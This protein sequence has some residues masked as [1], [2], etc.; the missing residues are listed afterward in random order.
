MIRDVPH[1]ADV[2][3][4]SSAVH[5]LRRV[6]TA[7]FHS[8]QM[9]GADEDEAEAEEGAGAG[10]GSL[11][12][13][14]FTFL[15]ALISI[16]GTKDP[17]SSS[18]KK[19]KQKQAKAGS[20]EGEEDGAPSWLDLQVLALSTAA[21]F[22]AHANS[23]AGQVAQGS[24]SLCWDVTSW[25]FRALLAGGGPSS[26]SAYESTPSSS[27]SSASPTTSPELIPLLTLNLSGALTTL[28]QEFCDDY[29][30]V[31]YAAVRI[32]RDAC[33][34]KRVQLAA[35]AAAATG[36]KGKKGL[37]PGSKRRRAEAAADGDEG[38]E[39]GDGSA[40]SALGGG[41][42][43]LGERLVSA[44]HSH[45]L[46]RN[47]AD[48]LLGI[49]LPLD[50]GEWADADHASFAVEQV[51]EEVD[52]H[53]AAHGLPAER[54]GGAATTDAAAA[55]KAGKK[56]AKFLSANSDSED[57]EQ[58]G[59]DDEEADEEEEEDGSGGAARRG[60]KGGRRGKSASAGPRYTLLSEQRRAY[61]E[62]WIALLRL[63]SLPADVVRRVLLALPTRVLPHLVSER[64]PLLLADF[65]TDAC[66]RGGAHALLALQSLFD[67]MQRHGLEYPR[68]YPR[69]YALLTPETAA[70][71]YRGKYLT[72]L[73]LFLSSPALPAY[74]T[75]AFAKRLA[76]VALTAPFGFALF[77]VP[78]LYNLCKRHPATQTL[79]HRG[80][81]GAG[82]TGVPAA[83]HVPAPSGKGGAAKPWPAPADPYDALTDEPSNCR[84]LESSLWEVSALQQH[85]HGPVANLARALSRGDFTRADYDVTL[86]AGESATYAA[87]V[88]GELTRTVRAQGGERASASIAFEFLA[89]A[90]VF[91]SAGGDLAGRA[92]EGVG[93]GAA[94]AAAAAAR[95]GGNGAAPAFAAG[96]LLDSVLDF[97]S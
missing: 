75:A 49:S 78:A 79:L 2:R 44:C 24:T 20:G 64:Q 50:E 67:L 71:K 40:A 32:V 52:A 1:D 41:P 34:G 66:D 68:F 8:G 10:R 25:L 4:L 46:A 7:H 15:E 17:T 14:F 26:A 22:M 11:R 29:D 84:A 51:G 58:L 74:L 83:P 92:R 43:R 61:G 48:F 63:P 39:D 94:A 23:I 81:A 59:G 91:A 53:R 54:R 27:S 57:D 77:A 62:A 38:D 69:L 13:S 56:R 88:D 82:A 42:S 47:A 3:V 86:F 19:K 30:D 65:L 12:A 70:A 9:R 60:G 28:R 90:A 87:A 96:H 55:P 97:G 89:P 73:D 76:R 35:A 21:H 18:S 31:R 16:V 6:Y 33:V 72:L 37:G 93:S 80:G 36:K 45:V 95:A 5:A 85:Y